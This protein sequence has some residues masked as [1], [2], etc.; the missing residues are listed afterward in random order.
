MLEAE[1]GAHEVSTT[2]S[3]EKHVDKSHVWFFVSVTDNVDHLVF[4]NKPVAYELTRKKSSGMRKNRLWL[5]T[6]LKAGEVVS[7]AAVNQ[8]QNAAVF[9]TRFRPISGPSSCCC[10]HRVPLRC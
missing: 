1:R 9:W 8:V 10:Y 5:K 2:W 6:I 4:K 7:E 3:D